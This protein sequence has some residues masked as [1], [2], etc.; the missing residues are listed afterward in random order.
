MRKT[1]LLLA[2]LFC[3]RA[4][5]QT[6]P[7]EKHI[8][9]DAFGATAVLDG[10]TSTGEGTCSAV[11]IDRHDQ[12]YTL[13]SAAHCLGNVEYVQPPDVE[14]DHFYLMSEN[15]QD[16]KVRL[17][18]DFSD[19]FFVAPDTI[20]DWKEPVKL[21]KIGNFDAGLDYSILSFHHE[22]ATP[23]PSAPLDPAPLAVGD[24]IFNVSLP[25]DRFKMTL[26]GTVARTDTDYRIWH[27]ALAL[28]MPGVT[29]G[30]SGSA[31]FDGAGH[32]RAVVVGVDPDNPGIVMAIPAAEILLGN[33]SQ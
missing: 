9:W 31:I 24:T 18:L 11:I 2:C 1:W 29:H 10:T 6:V 14:S 33:P 19:K 26:F 15:D 8:L 20:E 27:H 4:N 13:L 16:L 21:L 30:S 23:L 5:S 17:Q 32:V 25:L 28:Q 22:S 3:L 7:F 12:D